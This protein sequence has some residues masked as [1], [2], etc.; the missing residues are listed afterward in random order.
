MPKNVV[1][2]QRARRSGLRVAFVAS[3]YR[4][5]SLLCSACAAVGC[6]LPLWHRNAEDCRC[7]AVR[8][9]L[10]S[11]HCLRRV[12]TPKK[13]RFRCSTARAPL[14]AAH[15]LCRIRMP[16]NVVALLTLI[17]YK[18]RSTSGIQAKTG[19]KGCPHSCCWYPPPQPTSRAPLFIVSNESTHKAD[20]A[21]RESQEHKVLSK[22]LS[23]NILLG[24]DHNLQGQIKH[25]QAC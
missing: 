7:S 19:L 1:S 18:A 11:A 9:P 3:E 25:E 13:K 5:I 16:K 17:L 20:Q 4:R 10:W 14:W 21:G 6:A 24:E 8:T 23:S 22:G 2:L 12:R 15:C